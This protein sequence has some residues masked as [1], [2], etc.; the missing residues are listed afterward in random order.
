[1]KKT[2]LFSL[3]FIIAAT[4]TT[5]AQITKGSKLLGGNLSFGQSKLD[6][7]IAQSEIKSSTFNI[8]PSIGIAV[9]ENLIAGVNIGYSTGKQKQ[10]S[11]N[12]T[13]LDAKITGFVAGVFIRKYKQLAKSNFYLFGE[14]ALDYSNMKEERKEQMPDQFT[15]KTHSVS[16]SVKPGVSYAVNNRLHLELGLNNLFN[17]GYT[18]TK[19]SNNQNDNTV[20]QNSFGVSTNITNISNNISVGVRFLL[21]K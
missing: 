12:L 10:V 11:S 14:G 9:K 19:Q 16:L 1:M 8:S 4:V 5:Q 2:V 13:V 18:A 7:D 21:A 17:A 3:L 20:K 15:T 6:S